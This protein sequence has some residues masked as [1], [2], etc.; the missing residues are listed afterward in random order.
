MLAERLIWAVPAPTTTLMLV[1]PWAWEW[2]DPVKDVTAEVLAIDNPLKSRSASIGEAGPRPRGMWTSRFR[3][4]Q[5]SE[6]SRPSTREK[7]AARI[8]NDGEVTKLISSPRKIQ[9]ESHEDLPRYC[10]HRG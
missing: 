3:E 9:G 4:D 5:Q 2:V 6:Q 10:R 7:S 1:K 8:T